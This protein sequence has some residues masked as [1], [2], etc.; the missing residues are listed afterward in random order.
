MRLEAVLRVD[1]SQSMHGGK[2]EIA[3]GEMLIRRHVGGTYRSMPHS[4]RDEEEDIVVQADLC[5]RD[6]TGR[7][8]LNKKI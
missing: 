7:S 4:Q 3:L 6:N 2:I 5:Q 1:V 8:I